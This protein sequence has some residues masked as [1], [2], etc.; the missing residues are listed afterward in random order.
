MR[1]SLTFHIARVL[2]PRVGA[3]FGARPI[4]DLWPRGV[5]SFTFDDFPKSALTTG[6]AILERHGARGTYYTALKLAGIENNLG[7]SFDESDVVAAYQ[8]GHE[9]ACHTHTHLNCARSSPSAIKQEIHA[10]ARDFSG[11]L[12]GAALKNFAYPYGAVSRQAR[13]SLIW[14]FQSCRGIRPGLNKAVPAL[15]ELLANRIYA[16]DFDSERIREMIAQNKSEKSWL[17][18]YTHDVTNDPSPYGCTPEQF[19]TVVAE[20]VKTS[21]VLTVRDVIAS[22]RGAG[23]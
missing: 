6:G 17:I 13:R 1:Q 21:P 22:L 19:E 5:V 20:A 9:I 14:R 16:R 2:G 15:A 7:P 23:C 10:N 12:A 8:K 4:S 18:F 3:W 11:L